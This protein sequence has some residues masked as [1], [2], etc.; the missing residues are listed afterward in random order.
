MWVYGVI[1]RER[2]VGT[3]GLHRQGEKGV[4]CRVTPYN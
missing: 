2:G 1:V 3:D 4:G